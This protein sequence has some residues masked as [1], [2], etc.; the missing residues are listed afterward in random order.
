MPRDH[1]SS[2]TKVALVNALRLQAAALPCEA[3]ETAALLDQY[4]SDIAQPSTAK[5]TLSK[6]NQIAFHYKELRDIVVPG[7]TDAEW[8]G[9]V[10]ELRRLVRAAVRATDLENSLFG[11]LSAY[12]PSLGRE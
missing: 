5:A 1:L 8:L 12:V 2:A 3:G 7:V 10:I 6:L 11:R 4:A 9:K